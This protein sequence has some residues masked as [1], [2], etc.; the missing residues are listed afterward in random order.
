[1]EAEHADA[2][3]RRRAL[4]AAAQRRAVQWP[5]ESR[6]EREVARANELTPR[7]KPVSAF[8]ALIDLG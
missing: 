2:G 7:G 3:P 5:A 8:A 1:V 6:T 4:E